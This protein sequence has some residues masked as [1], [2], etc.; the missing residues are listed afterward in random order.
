VKITVLVPSERYLD[1]A[2]VRIRYNRISGALAQLG[3]TLQVMPID[4]VPNVSVDDSRIYLFSKCQ[5]A[6]ALALATAAKHAGIAVGVDL[7]D[8][9]FSQKT[10]ARFASQRLWLR[11]M[12]REASFFLCSTARMLYVGNSYFGAGAGHV[13]GDPRDQLRPER[14]EQELD[15][16]I[17]KAKRERRISILWFGISDNPNFPV[18]LHDLSAFGETL[19]PFH[20]NSYTARLTILTNRK[21]VDGRVLER[22]CRIPVPFVIREWTE[23]RQREALSR[24]LVSF[25]PVNFQQFSSA[26]SLNRGVSA[27][28]GGTQLLTAGY[29]L[30]ES[31][32]DYTYDDAAALIDDLEKGTLKLS[33]ENV[34][35]FSAW[36]D[37]RASPA[38]EAQGIVNFLGAKVGF[39]PAESDEEQQWAVLH[40]VKSTASINTFARRL[41]WLSLGSPLSPPGMKCD[42]HLGFFGDESALKLRVSQTG[43]E[44]LQEEFRVAALWAEPG[45]GKGPSWE[46]PLD[47]LESEFP[48]ESIRRSTGRGACVESARNVEIMELTRRFFTTVFHGLRV[49]ESELDPVRNNIRAIDPT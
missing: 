45:A 22:L 39:S 13:F 33:S 14:L 11:S 19:R 46:V 34:E 6:R 28:V 16:K 23:E 20:D 15:A 17:R 40:G 25:L 18:G 5:D 4:D 44:H 31:L 3:W 47:S 38:R 27:L 26:K 32:G 2:G 43:L 10:D 9:Y 41:G 36:V 48:L 37:E 7:F 21:G 29:P 8:D 12:A 30:Y 24:S 49:I 42:A 1:T 35:E